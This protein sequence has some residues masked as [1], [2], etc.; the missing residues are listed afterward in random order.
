MCH[1]EGEA[2]AGTS[3]KETACLFQGLIQIFLLIVF[4]MWAKQNG[5]NQISITPIYIS[6]LYIDFI[7]VGVIITEANRTSLL[8][9]KQESHSEF[10]SKVIRMFPLLISDCC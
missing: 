2:R 9:K 4:R 7:M 3:F 6:L 5:R 10:L 1:A 8:T